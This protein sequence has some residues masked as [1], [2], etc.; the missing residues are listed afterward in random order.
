[1]L[2]EAPACIEWKAVRL[3]TPTNLQ[4]LLQALAQMITNGSVLTVRMDSS[5]ILLQ[6]SGLVLIAALRCL[7]AQ[8]A[9]MVRDA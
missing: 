2:M 7:T 5:G 1:M 3:I 6:I 4:D 8:N 9:L